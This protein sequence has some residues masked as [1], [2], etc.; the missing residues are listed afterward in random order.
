MNQKG[1][2]C[3]GV[4]VMP[5]ISW[6]I[7]LVAGRVAM[8][9]GLAGNLIVLPIAV[10]LAVVCFIIVVNLLKAMFGR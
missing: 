6:I 2:N 3:Y 1:L 5:L 4:L 10:L 8:L 9:V 7:Y